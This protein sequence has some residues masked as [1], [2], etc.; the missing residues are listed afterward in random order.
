MFYLRFIEV[1]T[2]RYPMSDMSCSKKEYEVAYDSK[3]DDH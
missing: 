2:F 1:V 3:E